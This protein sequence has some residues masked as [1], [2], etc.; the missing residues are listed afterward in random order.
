MKGSRNLENGSTS[1]V[2]KD[3]K[4]KRTQKERKKEDCV[5]VQYMECREQQN[6]NGKS[7]VPRPV[8]KSLR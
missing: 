2:Y 3:Y 8:T 1:S 6:V 5:K 4:E 7:Q